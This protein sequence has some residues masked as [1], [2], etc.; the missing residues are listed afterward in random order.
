MDLDHVLTWNRSVTSLRSD[1]KAA[2]R[3]EFF[4]S[5]SVAITCGRHHIGRDNQP[6]G[7]SKHKTVG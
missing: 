6:A 2:R 5:R 1:E 7:V 3:S 4:F